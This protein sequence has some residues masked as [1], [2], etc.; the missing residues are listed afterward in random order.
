[1]FLMTG[2]FLVGHHVSQKL[3][4]GR[5]LLAWWMGVTALQSFLSMWELVIKRPLGFW[6]TFPPAIGLEYNE[7]ALRGARETLELRL[8]GELRSSTSAPIHIVLSAI[9]AT[10]VI[11][12]GGWF[13]SARTKRERFWSGLALVA[14]LLGLPA[15]NSRTGFLIVIVMAIPLA[16]SLGRFLPRFLPAAVLG[17]VLMA[18]SFIISPA[19]PRLLLDSLTQPTQDQNVNVR[20]ERFAV[21]PDLLSPRYAFGAGY[22]THDV[23]IQLFDNA[24]NLGL[25]EFGI[26]GLAVVLLFFLSILNR[27][28]RAL[29]LA[30]PNE[31]ILPFAGIAAVGSLLVAMSTL[32]A[33]SFDQ[34]FPGLMLVMGLGVGRSALILSRR[35]TLQSPR[36]RD[37][38]GHLKT[39]P[40]VAALAL[41]PMVV[42]AGSRLLRVVP[43]EIRFADADAGDSRFGWG[44]ALAVTTAAVRLV[45]K[46]ISTRIDEVRVRNSPY[47]AVLA[48]WP[49]RLFG[50]T[51][52]LELE[53]PPSPLQDDDL[54]TGFG[55]Q[56]L[57]RFAARVATRAVAPNE[58]LREAWIEA[59][60]AP[61]RISVSL[62]NPGAAIPKGAALSR[63]RQ[64]GPLRVVLHGGMASPVDV[65]SAMI[66]VAE[67]MRSMSL[68]VTI[69]L[70]PNEPNDMTRILEKLHLT[71]SVDV[72]RSSRGRLGDV[73]LE[74]DVG[75][76]LLGDTPESDMVLPR[77]LIDYIHLGLPVVCTRTDAVSDLFDEEHVVYVDRG[78]P[79]EVAHAIV[80]LQVRGALR[81]NMAIKAL[82]RLEAIR[83]AAKEPA[84]S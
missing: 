9:V 34:Y 60:F 7:K 74:A 81:R 13:I 39:R 48:A 47:W 42:A 80:K 11:L 55:T 16:F 15:S 66:A 26:V 65:R 49:V 41:E 50:T 30:R 19:T 18:A 44:G 4:T 46:R 35:S 59:G 33:L 72:V 69:V 37:Q 28:R 63:K 54:F 77:A 45:R 20:V 24:Y 23:E 12:A 78:Q 61:G 52:V 17:A 75:L 51:V 10:G 67:V 71:E 82:N 21:L 43:L 14:C 70:G 84:K 27:C 83:G 3:E 40:Q 8:T 56:L 2:L 64:K 36:V 62:W 58:R 53:Q 31:F 1:M 57:Q 76:V 22:M 5:K 73:L 6:T 68:D 79:L 38:V 25:I 32:D 29:H